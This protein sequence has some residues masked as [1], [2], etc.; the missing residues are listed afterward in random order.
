MRN[1]VCIVAKN[2]YR[3]DPSYKVSEESTTIMARDW[4]GLNN[5]GQSCVVVE[6]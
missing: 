3:D 4:K 2:I 5:Y 1:K 6:L